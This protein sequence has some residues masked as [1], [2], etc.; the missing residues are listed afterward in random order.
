[1]QMP[2]VYR[3]I[4]LF[5]LFATAEVSLQIPSRAQQK[6][7]SPPPQPAVEQQQTAFPIE[8][9][10]VEGNKQFAAEK[11]I[12]V[13]GLKIGQTVEKAD[14]EKAHQRLR[15]TGAFES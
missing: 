2:A 3:K 10:K 7:K 12:E 8:T 6:K 15:A 5:L 9:L 1:M 13:S 14:F 11:I 4:S